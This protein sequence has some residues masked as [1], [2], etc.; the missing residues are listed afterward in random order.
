MHPKY[1]RM[2]KGM[3]AKEKANKKLRR[4]ESW[5]L[6]IL[7]CSDKTFYTG[8]TNDLQRRFKM[9]NNG[10]ASRYTR[11]RRPVKLVYQETCLSRTHA[12]VRECA[13]KALPR[14]QKEKL[15]RKE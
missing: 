6:Y 11:T 7:E 3:L 14:K 10:K 13:V 5:F 2:L 8:V 9:H 1:K 4:K 12:L 15:V